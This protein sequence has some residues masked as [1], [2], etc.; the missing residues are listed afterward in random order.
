ML[1][2][3]LVLVALSAACTDPDPDLTATTHE[4]GAS[5]PTREHIAGDVYH[6]SFALPVGDG[7]NARL[8]IHR[9]TRERAPW[10]PRRSRRALVLM[11]GDFS[12]F[13][14]NFDRMAP[15]LAER[16]IDVWGFDRR[17]TQAPETGADVSDFATMGLAEELADIGTALAFVRG[18]RLV[19]DGSDER[20]TLG[21]FS[22][23][24]QL[25]YYYASQEMLAPPQLR[26]VHGLVPLDVY[27]SISPADDDRRQYF[28][29]LAGFEYDAYNAGFIDSPNTFIFDVG[30][31][32]LSAPNDVS[33]YAFFP[34]QTNRGVLF[35]T[36][37]R[38]YLFF[39]PNPVYHLIAP[40]IDGRITGLR[41]SNETTV[42]TWLANAAPHQSMLE[43]AETDAMLCNEAPPVDAP[44]SRIRVPLL[45]LAAA[46]GYG[47]RALFSTT[48][49]SSPDVTTQVIRLLPA[50]QEAEDFGHADLLFAD[51]APALAWQPL[52]SWLNAL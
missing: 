3:F 46:G 37:G 15:W 34:G 2:L 29:E 50:E 40:V 52:L 17:W 30:R 47:E 39:A 6:Y 25:A 22:R 27:A 24:G 13:W 12:T 19:T 7:P 33:P 28:C 18:V 45:L 51:N 31:L 11:H 43:Q 26:H 1:R 14:T 10:Q 36:V 20:V 9:V 49:V 21:G 4:L 41:Y 16:G 42:A 8:T 23:G 44:L 38:T 5:A 32:A 48:Q 35:T